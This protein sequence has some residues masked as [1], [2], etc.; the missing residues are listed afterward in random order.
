MATLV[1]N[2]KNFKVFKMSY[3]ECRSLHWG[4]QK[5][6]ICAHCNK[7]IDKNEGVYYICV[8]HDTMCKSCYEEWLNGATNYPEDKEYENMICNRLQEELEKLYYI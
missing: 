8:L 1:E 7:I 2:S 5:G 3:P 4:I 6:I